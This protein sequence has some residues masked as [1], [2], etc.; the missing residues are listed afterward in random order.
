MYIGNIGHFELTPGLQPCFNVVLQYE[1]HMY[2]GNV[3]HFGLTPGLQPCF[4]VVLQYEI[5]IL[6]TLATLSLPLGYRLVLM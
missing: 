4:N 6:G 2:I 5:H 3:G 1:I